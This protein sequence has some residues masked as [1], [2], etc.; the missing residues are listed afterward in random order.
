MEGGGGVRA[1]RYVSFVSR[2]CEN[3]FGNAISLTRPLLALFHPPAPFAPVPYSLHGALPVLVLELPIVSVAFLIAFH[4]AHGGHRR[5][6]RSRSDLDRCLSLC[7]IDVSA[8]LVRLFH[9]GVR[10]N[11]RM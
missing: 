5:C 7:L 3:P 6:S 2:C 1:V 11:A 8:M 4:T 10:S 9:G